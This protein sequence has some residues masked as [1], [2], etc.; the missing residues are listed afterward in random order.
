MG[1]QC[2]SILEAAARGF[3]PVVSPDTGYPY[4]PPFCFAMEILSIFEVLKELLHTSADE[5]S[6]LADTLHHQLITDIN[7]NNWKRLTDVLVEEVK[8]LYKLFG[9]SNL[10]VDSNN[11]SRST[12]DPSRAKDAERKSKDIIELPPL[13]SSSS[14]LFCL[15]Q[16]IFY[17]VLAHFLQLS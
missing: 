5:R 16:V 10:L 2:V 7:H 13:R 9:M 1:A 14:L 4:T 8:A 3:I 15:L 6:H 11:S 17:S 12:L